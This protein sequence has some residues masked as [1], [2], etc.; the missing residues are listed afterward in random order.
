MQVEQEQLTIEE[1]RNAVLNSYAKFCELL[2][3]DGWFEENHRL[4]C[5][6]LQ[7]HF[8]EDVK[9]NKTF[10]AL[11]VLPRASLKSTI[12]TKYF[13]V[14][15]TLRYRYLEGD[16]SVRSLIATNTMPNAGRKLS[17]IRGLFDSHE[18][19]RVLFPDVLPSS[20]CTWTSEALQ[21]PRK[22]EYPEATFESAGMRTKLTGRHYNG[23]LEDDT[24]APDEDEMG[25]DI[26]LPS[27]ETIER[28]I[29]WHKAA[30]PLLMP[31]G[32]SYSIVVATRWSDDDLVDYLKKHE[33]YRI[34]D[35]PAVL[36]RGNGEFEYTFPNI[37]PKE[38]LEDIKKRVGPYMYSCLY[39]NAPMDVAKR[40]FQST[41]FD[42]VPKKAVPKHGYCSIA[43]D[44]AISEKDEACETAITAIQ[45]VPLINGKN[46]EEVQRVTEGDLL[47][48]HQY[49][50]HAEHGHFL[51]N[52][53]IKRTLDLAEHMQLHIAPVKAII[54]ETVAFQKV[55]KYL[56]EDE[57]KRRGLYFNIICHGTRTDKD[58]RIQG[59]QP[60][61]YQKIIHFVEDHLPDAVES[62]LLQY[63]H[64]RLVDIIDCFTL[65]KPCY[66][67][68]SL[69]SFAPKKKT[70]EE[71]L[72]E[73]ILK[74]R[75]KKNSGQR[76]LTDLSHIETRMDT[77]LKTFVYPNPRLKG[78]RYV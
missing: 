2:Q 7:Y 25:K 17:D 31:R 28:A 36:D 55:L 57:M 35:L 37:Y 26:T 32:M 77:G 61:F 52:D 13:P 10:K 16:D 23:I 46:P 78:Q 5:N 71:E 44:P 12:V 51:P 48:N 75:Q 56:F 47:E 60:L 42:Y 14:W 18:I 49:W 9:R 70:E 65:H 73:F 64:G 27:Q 43:I 67:Y 38:K 11:T 15:V 53:Q 59:L 33:D 22:R 66:K 54:I 20:T 19:F 72:S 34:F 6:W 8:L 68:S 1:L 29:G 30:I 50:W 3:D 41:W 74:N 4:L 58:L 76:F 69:T 24:T 21:L 39:L 62:Q 40:V 63:P 45:H